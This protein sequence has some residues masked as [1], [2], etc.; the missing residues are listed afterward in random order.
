MRPST[1]LR[2][3]LAGPDI[4]VAPGVYDG[5]S[6]RLACRAGFP[7]VYATGGG[8]ARSMGYPDLGL[9]GLVEVA[10]RVASIA[11]HSDVPVVAAADTGYGNP[12]S[13][14][15]TVR[16]FK[17]AGV[18][19][20]HLE[21]QQFPKRCGHYDDKSVVPV[22]EMAQ[23]IR[24][25]R[26]AATDAD[27]VIIARTDAIAVEGFEAALARTQA[28]AE[29]GA[30]MLFVESPQTE[31]QIKAVPARLRAPQLI[32]M[33]LGGRTPLVPLERLRAWGYRIVII[34]SD[35]QRAA[36]RAM[37]GCW[38]PSGATATA[39]LW[40]GAWPRSRS[41]RPWWTRR[42]TSSS[43]GGTRA[44]RALHPLEPLIDLHGHRR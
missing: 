23:K 4:I 28:Y 15:G 20:F 24:A 43:T 17:R 8:I 21:D 27:L 34:P 37:E 14:R 22:E 26:E 5:L 19:A 3:L 13:V 35:L 31:A 41:G 29:A 10:D 1:R 18:A 33:F 16:A 30:D 32:N 42:G 44:G 38:R 7:A 40:P 11:E 2:Q 25:A 9:L 12:L 6:A 39:R 36:I